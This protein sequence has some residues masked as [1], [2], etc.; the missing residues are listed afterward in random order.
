M[1]HV[2]PSNLFNEAEQKRLQERLSLRG[3]TMLALRS[4]RRL[5]RDLPRLLQPEM[6]PS[7]ATLI[8][9]A[10]APAIRALALVLEP[11]PRLAALLRR[12]EEEG[13]HVQTLLRGDDLIR[14]GIPRGPQMR[15]VLQQLR[16]AR[17]DGAVTSLAEEDAL[18]RKL[19]LIA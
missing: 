2:S 18:V 16:A 3:E 10:I 17:L 8:L 12:Y 1:S 19:A 4:A 15:H 9:D 7:R 11:S 13:R 14:L 5:H 6:T